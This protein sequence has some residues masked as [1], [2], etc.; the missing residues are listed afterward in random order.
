MAAC[1]PED[2]HCCGESTASAQGRSGSASALELLECGRIASTATEPS[3]Y[4]AARCPTLPKAMPQISAFGG[5]CVACDPAVWA[6]AA[7]CGGSSAL[8]RH[9]LD[10]CGLSSPASRSESPPRCA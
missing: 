2:T 1:A 4:T 6:A 8:L 3:L 10:F 5:T 7:C 9:Q